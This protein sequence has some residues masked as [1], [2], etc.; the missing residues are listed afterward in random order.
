V[1]KLDKK[2]KEV[3]R[4]NLAFAALVNSNG[5]QTEAAELLDFRSQDIGYYM[6]G[7]KIPIELI[8]ACRK[9]YG[10]DLLELSKMDFENMSLKKNESFQTKVSRETKTLIG[11]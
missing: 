3:P 2:E 1:K 5:N 11:C 7:R 8:E 9:K 10:Y 4:I 6:R